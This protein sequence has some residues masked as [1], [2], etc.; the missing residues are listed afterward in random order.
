MLHW[1]TPAATSNTPKFIRV[2]L[3]LCWLQELWPGSRGDRGSFVPGQSHPAA[4]PIDAIFR[5]PRAAQQLPQTAPAPRSDTPHNDGDEDD[6]CTALSPR[7]PLLPRVPLGMP[8]L[9][10]FPKGRGAASLHRTHG[11]IQ[12]SQE[13]AAPAAAATA[14]VLIPFKSVS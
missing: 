1:K 7:R 4:L 8:P 14:L 13:E 6:F 10:H 12:P 11:H 3:T 9:P 5:H 2:G